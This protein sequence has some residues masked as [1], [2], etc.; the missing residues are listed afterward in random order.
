MDD[1]TSVIWWMKTFGPA[2]VIVFG[3]GTGFW[4]ICIFLKPIILDLAAGHVSL[5]KS[6]EKT[7]VD[8]SKA[9]EDVREAQ[10]E[11]GE[12]IGEIHQKVTADTP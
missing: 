6:L 10:K 7:Q 2:G 3:L 9:I 8:Q 4:K 11:H 5:M 1:P 12:L